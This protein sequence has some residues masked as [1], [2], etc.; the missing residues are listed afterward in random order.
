MQV[1]PEVRARLRHAFPALAGDTVFLENAGG[2]QVP[3]VVADRIRDYMLSSYVQLGAGYP[4]SE[5]A[6]RTVDEAHDFVR[7][8]FN[9]GDGEV[10]LGSSTSALLHMLAD[11]YAK[12]LSPGDEIVVAEIGHE[13]NVGPWTSLERIGVELRWW[14]MDRDTC[15]SPLDALAAL[16]TDRTALVAF[17]H[18]SNLLGGILDVAEITRIVHDAGARV[19]VDGVAYAPHRAMDVAAWGVDVYAYSTYKVYGPHMGAMWAS[20]DA[21]AEL[22]GP[23]HFFIPAD[24]VPYKFELGGVSHEGCAG[25][26]GLRD[27]IAELGGVEEPAAVDRS[28]VERAFDLMTACELPL[29]HRLVEYLQSR[30]DVRIVGPQHAGPSRVG[31]ISFVHDARSSAEITEVVDRSG[32]AI[33]HGHMYAYHLCEALGLDPDDGVVRVSL[34]HYNT[35]DEIERL[36]EVLDRAMG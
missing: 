23:N 27:Y 10:I 35:P 12:T 6:T 9:G 30:D 15:E 16:L 20:R 4:L 19:V 5:V 33:R 2:S 13:A 36:I 11:C 26:L 7:L 1:T 3:A 18:V 21:L 22:E 24:E 31:T 34:V 28:A 32:V 25:I 17:P 14:R 8:L 29:Q